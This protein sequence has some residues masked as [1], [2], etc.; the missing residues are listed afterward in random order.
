LALWPWLDGV[1]GV[2]PVAARAA[3]AA[4]VLLAIGAAVYTWRGA[5][6]AGGLLLT[7]SLAPAVCLA[8]LGGHDAL[9]GERRYQEWAFVQEVAGAVQPG[10]TVFVYRCDESE[11]VYG[12]NQQVHQLEEPG[13]PPAA[14]P[15]GRW[16]LIT[17][18]TD[19]RDSAGRWPPHALIRE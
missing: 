3:G 7:Q 11:L 13:V 15:G 4:L 12:L 18:F 2:E 5:T 1:G 8:L 14:V 10:D 19:W 9:W 17:D 6:A 16:W